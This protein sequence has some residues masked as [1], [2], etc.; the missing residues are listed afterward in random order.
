MICMSCHNWWTTSDCLLWLCS[1][2]LLF[3][4]WAPKGVTYR[5][6]AG[7]C[8][9]WK[10]SNHSVSF[11]N[12]VKWCVRL[13]V[14]NLTPESKYTFDKHMFLEAVWNSQATHSNLR[15]YSSSNESFCSCYPFWFSLH[16][17]FKLLLV[18]I[19][20]KQTFLRHLHLIHG[21]LQR[22]SLFFSTLQCGAIAN[23]NHNNTKQFWAFFKRIP[24]YSK[25]NSLLSTLTPLPWC[26]D[27]FKFLMFWKRL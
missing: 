25:F 1:F 13:C 17:L 3:L 27:H 9:K 11:V 2:D 10:F 22:S 5:A 15:L 21:I 18:F 24:T 6:F 4:F 8:C 23:P 20:S 19:F 12:W 16:V 7:G 26:P 14:P